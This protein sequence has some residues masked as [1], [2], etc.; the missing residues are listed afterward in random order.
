MNF[1]FIVLIYFVAWIQFTF[2]DD[3]SD[4]DDSC[5]NDDI[6][7]IET[8]TPSTSLGGQNIFPAAY[9]GETKQSSTTITSD[10]LVRLLVG[11]EDP[12]QKF[13][14]GVFGSGSAA[15]IKWYWKEDGNADEKN[16]FDFGSFV[17]DPKIQEVQFSNVLGLFHSQ[18][19]FVGKFPT[20]VVLIPPDSLLGF[21]IMD[22]TYGEPAQNCSL[23]SSIQFFAFKWVDDDDIEEDHMDLGKCS[24]WPFGSLVFRLCPNIISTNSNTTSQANSTTNEAW[25]F[26]TEDNHYGNITHCILT[27][28]PLA[29][30]LDTDQTVNV[31]LQIIFNDALNLNETPSCWLVFPKHVTSNISME[32][33]LH[34]EQMILRTN[35]SDKRLFEGEF[36]LHCL[37]STGVELLPGNITIL[38]ANFTALVELSNPL[39]TTYYED[40]IDKTLT[41]VFA[42]AMPSQFDY[43]P[44]CMLDNGTV[45]DANA[46]FSAETESPFVVSC[47]LNS[48]PISIGD[49]RVWAVRDP[50]LLNATLR[51]QTPLSVHLQ[52]KQIVAKTVAPP[53]AAVPQTIQL[54]DS[55][56]SIV[57]DYGGTKLNFADTF[58]CSSIFTDVSTLGASPNCSIAS[59]SF[60][61]AILGQSTTVKVGD[62]LRLYS[63]D[64]TPGKIPEKSAGASAIS[65]NL[66]SPNNPTSPYA[67]LQPSKTSFGCMNSEDISIYAKP[68]S[69]NGQRALNCTWLIGGVDAKD[70]EKLLKSSGDCTLRLPAS[71][72]Q[73]LHKTN[74]NALVV[75]ATVCNL[76]QKCTQTA[77]IAISAEANSGT[78]FSV[79]ITGIPL[80]PTSSQR[81]TLIAEPSLIECN[82]SKSLMLTNIKDSTITIPARLYEANDEISVILFAKH[83][84]A[85]GSNSNVFNATTSQTIKYATEPLVVVM[86]ATSKTVA[87]DEQLHID[88]SKCFSP[89]GPARMLSHLWTFLTLPPNVLT[90]NGSFM[91][92]DKMS[93]GFVDGNVRVRVRVMPAQVPSVKFMPLSSIEEP[94]H[95]QNIVSPNTSAITTQLQYTVQDVIQGSG[96]F[97]RL[98]AFVHSTSGDLYT[99]WQLYKLSDNSSI[100]LSSLHMSTKNNFTGKTASS[101]NRIA[102]SFTLPT[103]KSSNG[104]WSGLQFDQDY[105]LRLVATNRNGMGYAD[106]FFCVHNPPTAAR[107]L[108]TPNTSISALQ[109]PVK[110][111]VTGVGDIPL[112]LT[113][114]GTKALLVGN[115]SQV[116]WSRASVSDHYEILLP[117][118]WP[119]P[120]ASCGDRVGFRAMVELCDIWNA[121][122]VMESEPFVVDHALNSTGAMSQALALIDSR[123]ASGDIFKAID[124][125]ESVNLEQCGNAFSGNVV[126]TVLND[127]MDVTDATN[128]VNELME[129]LGYMMKVVDFASPSVMKRMQ[130][131]LTDHI[132]HSMGWESSNETMAKNQQRTRRSVSLMSAM[133]SGSGGGKEITEAAASTLLVAYDI[134]VDKNQDVVKVYLSNIQDILSG[135]CVQADSSRTLQA[136]GETYTEVESQAIVPGSSG[137]VNTSFP[138][139]GLEGDIVSFD[140]NFASAY[141]VWL[142]SNGTSCTDICLATAQTLTSALKDNTY[143]ANYFFSSQYSSITLDQAVSDFYHIS[144]LDPISGKSETLRSGTQMVVKLPISKYLP[145]AYYKCFIFTALWDDTACDSSN[146]ASLIDPSSPQKFQLT[147]T[148]RKSGVIGVFTTTPPTPPSYPPY[149]EIQLYFL[150]DTTSQPT[151]TQMMTFV[152]YLSAASGVF[153]QRFVALNTTTDTSGHIVITAKLRPPFKEGQLSNS[154]AMQSIRRTIHVDGGFTAYGT[155]KVMNLTDYIVYRVLSGDHNAR[156]LTF[157]IDRSYKEIVGNESDGYALSGKWTSK[158]ASNMR[159]SAY[160]FKNPVVSTGIIFNFTIT[161]PF[162]GET[163]ANGVIL[164]AEEISKWIQEQTHYGELDLHDSRD[165]SLPVDPLENGEITELR[166]L[167]PTGTL[168]VVVAIV[169]PTAFLLISFCVSGLVFMKIRTDRLIESHNSNL[170]KNMTTIDISQ[171]T[172]INVLP[173][174]SDDGEHNGLAHNQESKA[175]DTVVFGRRRRTGKQK[176][177]GRGPTRR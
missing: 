169:V 28:K 157:K 39:S 65:L 113:R 149:N 54:S 3:D 132:K 50:M 96:G 134:L 7:P 42:V 105:M 165:Q 19:N 135:F 27:V 24:A 22:S 95:D 1:R 26:C 70:V 100:D 124:L 73:L 116:S 77:A 121:C 112:M 117:S 88:T 150:M 25:Q 140:T 53:G 125:M 2:T 152:D 12:S 164:A 48:H 161:V 159:I 74:A 111:S 154:Y 119:E 16:I 80:N 33:H 71:F 126:D 139:A 56:D 130:D 87:T 155:V 128:D 108:V 72:L 174:Q 43:T 175:S 58:D 21:Q 84:E 167:G 40:D 36:P 52:Q 66:K 15:Q 131:L 32:V 145:S 163:G 133:A 127:V 137:F 31:E 62:S 55:L 162:D 99:E 102:V 63:L 17:G 129:G 47:D 46:V 138:I 176:Q 92:V 75:S 136:S 44:N 110:F 158:M 83:A 141:S 35:D 51:G 85:D 8:F 82:S 160:R 151:S 91:F 67:S 37:S 93:D 45:G 60:I 101:G 115:R 142:C 143:L 18:S 57:I 61:I 30:D 122:T 146:Y 153:S 23:N 166:V 14:I 34:D 107:I 118:A 172:P 41:A 89:N 20:K 103:K 13:G 90:V 97:I 144:L 106:Y 29:F 11:I 10:R 170:A 171:A 177:N 94:A 9:K 173:F 4:E 6:S 76:A 5:S 114:F 98:Q 123:I 78:L 120:H 64:N 104:N 59:S 147:C 38:V 109:T 68:I 79:K 148:C 69:G 86:D 49:H 168:M 156:R 81:I